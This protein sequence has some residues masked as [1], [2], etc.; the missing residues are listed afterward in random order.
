MQYKYLGKTTQRIPVIGQGGMGLGGELDRD[1]SQAEG[2][3]DALRLGIELGMT[4]IDTAEGYGRGRS[5]ELVGQAIAG[6]RQHVVIATKCSPEHNSYSGVLE[7][8]EG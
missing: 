7:A 2:Q 8:V 3:V 1:D 6:I 5:E 4:L